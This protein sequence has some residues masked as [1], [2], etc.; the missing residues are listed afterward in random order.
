MEQALV[1]KGL[2]RRCGYT[3][4][5]ENGVQLVN[6]RPGSASCALLTMNTGEML[7]DLT[8][9]LQQIETQIDRG[10]KDRAG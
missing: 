8:G 5:D 1:D 3:A 2:A 10:I 9:F 7:Q 6:A 4:I